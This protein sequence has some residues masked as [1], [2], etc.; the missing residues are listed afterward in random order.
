M[1]KI[2]FL[3]AIMVM[4]FA[5]TSLADSSHDTTSDVDNTAVAGAVAG[6]GVFDSGNSMANSLSSVSRSGNSEVDVNASSQNENTN[7]QGQRT[8]V[9]TTDV[10]VQGQGQKQGI[11]FSDDD[12]VIYK[13]AENSAA[14]AADLVLGTCQAG[15]SAQTQMGGGSLGG[16]DEVCLLFTLSQMYQ[17]QGNTEAANAVLKRAEDTLKWRNNVVRRAFQAI[18]LLGRMF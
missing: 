9:D 16:P 12:T 5:G 14:S 3:I 8:D 11:Q 6:A 10:S 1:N 7:V 18:P 2:A 13:E 4:A 15:L 17:A